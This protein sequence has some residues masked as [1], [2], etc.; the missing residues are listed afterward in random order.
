MID[1][2]AFEEKNLNK[3][4]GKLPGLPK[5]TSPTTVMIFIGVLTL[6]F[7]SPIVYN[8]AG[9]LFTILF[10]PAVFY[11]AYKLALKGQEM[12]IRTALF[13]SRNKFGYS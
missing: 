11:G 12:S 3:Y 13:A 4:A 9:R 8:S 7:I 5:L 10:V 2:S 1:Y 6:F